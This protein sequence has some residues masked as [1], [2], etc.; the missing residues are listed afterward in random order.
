MGD[1]ESETDQ[2][3][4]RGQCEANPGSQRSGPSG[5]AQ[6]KR[7]GDL[8]AGRSGQELAQRNQVRVSVVVEPATAL[9]EL[10]AEETQVGQWA[11]ERSQAE[12]KEGQQN[13]SCRPGCGRFGRRA[14]AKGRFVW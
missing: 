5:A 11:A 10:T 1:K 4:G 6:A 9:D 14:W 12:A 2:A 8:A 3:D 7:D 13:L